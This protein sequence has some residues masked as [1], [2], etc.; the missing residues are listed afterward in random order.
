MVFKRNCNIH[1]GCSI[2]D[3]KRLKKEEIHSDAG[4]IINQLANS[5]LSELI[6][7]MGKYNEHKL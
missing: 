1:H 5:L 2:F 6:K 7:L 4:I 3:V